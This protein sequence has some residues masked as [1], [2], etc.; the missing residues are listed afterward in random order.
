MSLKKSNHL[1]L[2]LFFSVC[3]AFIFCIWEFFTFLC[4]ALIGIHWTQSM[5]KL[6]SLP[7]SYLPQFL[8]KSDF[9]C[10]YWEPLCVPYAP[11]WELQDR[12]V[13]CS[14]RSEGGS[15]QFHLF[16][17]GAL[18][19]TF[20]GD[21]ICRQRWNQN[22]A[23]LFWQVLWASFNFMAAANI[24]SDFGAPKNKVWHCF[25]CFPIYFPW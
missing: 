8:L 5:Y 11:C 13:L 23:Y 16:D 1:G 25:H 7:F 18:P 24:C 22:L 3:I 14:P 2:I 21:E 6:L 19:H 12:G 20:Q 10:D 15:C 9:L 17:I 4:C